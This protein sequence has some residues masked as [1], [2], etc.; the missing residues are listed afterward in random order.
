[1]KPSRSSMIVLNAL[2]WRTLGPI[3]SVILV[4]YALYTLVFVK[5]PSWFRWGLGAL[6]GLVYGAGFIMMTPQLFINH[7]LKSVAHLPWR[8]LCYRAFN[9][10]IDDLLGFIVTMPTMHRIACFRDDVVFAI[11]LYQ[12]YTFPTDKTRV[13]EFG[14]SFDDNQRL[15]QE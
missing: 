1:M 10:I 8:V 6:V 13:N 9:T 4:C 11:F 2:A 7:R 12:R 3:L 5:Q 14:Q 15:K